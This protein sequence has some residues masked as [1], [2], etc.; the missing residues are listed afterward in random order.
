MII[1]GNLDLYVTTM[2]YG[3]YKKFYAGVDAEN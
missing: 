2:I 3:S 1:E